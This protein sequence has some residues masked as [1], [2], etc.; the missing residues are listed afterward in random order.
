MTSARNSRR[1]VCTEVS[2]I[3]CD[4]KECDVRTSHSRE[5]DVRTSDSP[6]FTPVPIKCDISPILVILRVEVKAA[7]YD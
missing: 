2:P 3:K 4:V 7:V 1:E 5:C 6:K